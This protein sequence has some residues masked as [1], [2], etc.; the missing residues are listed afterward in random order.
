MT[1]FKVF[2]IL[3]RFRYLCNLA[4]IIFYYLLNGKIKDFILL[5]LRTFAIYINGKKWYNFKE[6]D[7]VGSMMFTVLGSYL[8]KVQYPKHF[9]LDSEMLQPYFVAFVEISKIL[10]FFCFLL[11]KQDENFQTFFKKASVAIAHFFFSI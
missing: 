4:L 5:P 7:L 9:Q 10:A 1:S 2:L 8:C 11:E 6:L 3:F